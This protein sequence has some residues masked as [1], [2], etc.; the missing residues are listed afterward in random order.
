MADPA[1][2]PPFRPVFDAHN[3]PAQIRDL[4]TRCWLA[5]KAGR[6]T[7]QQLSVELRL[8]NV[9]DM[10]DALRAMHVRS[11]ACWR[12]RACRPSLAAA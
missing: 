4:C 6:P 10:N 3:T 11:R 9:S 1:L 5:E 8:L 7:F 12:R 2:D